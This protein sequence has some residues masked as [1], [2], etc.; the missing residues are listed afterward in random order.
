[1]LKNKEM[2]FH[3]VK[4]IHRIMVFETILNCGGT[5]ISNN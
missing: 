3:T 1:M 2:V 4:Q 5:E